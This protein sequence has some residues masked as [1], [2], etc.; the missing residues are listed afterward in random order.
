MLKKE[1]LRIIVK[2]NNGYLFTSDEQV[3]SVSRTYLADFVRDNRMEKV[4]K[5]IYI[6]ED[7][8]PDDLY[9]MQKCY[10][11]IVFSGETA[12]YLHGLIEREYSEISVSVPYGFS[13]TRL[14]EKG[15]VIHSENPEIYN[16]G[17]A[18]VITNFGNSVR[19]HDRERSICDL[20][21]NREK[22]EVQNFQSAVKTY[23]KSKDKDLTTLVR[24]ADMLSVRDE[25]MKYIEVL[26]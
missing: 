22:I 18:E 2:K 21:K 8:W 10:P 25:I 9:I 26:V 7:T 23:M 6:A 3:A 16:L 20:V 17:I 13:G 5:G 1:Q 14:R 19:C 11:R 12:L 4:A 15:V 24:Y